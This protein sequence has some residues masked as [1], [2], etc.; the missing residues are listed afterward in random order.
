MSKYAAAPV[1]SDTETIGSD[2]DH[3]GFI[4]AGFSRTGG[5]SANTTKGK[6]PT[7][8]TTSNTIGGKM[9]YSSVSTGGATFVQSNPSAAI[10]AS[11]TTASNFNYD[12]LDEP[13]WATIV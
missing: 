8:T 12:T 9:T 7:L 3:E 13:V 10:P 4:G 5:S 6:A 1:L 11:S 2:D